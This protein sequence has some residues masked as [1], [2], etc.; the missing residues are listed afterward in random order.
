MGRALAISAVLLLVLGVI[1][2]ARPS[3]QASSAYAAFRPVTTRTSMEGEA[4]LPVWRLALQRL[5]KR[6]LSRALRA[7]A[8]RRWRRRSAWALGPLSGLVA[9]LFGPCGRLWRWL[10]G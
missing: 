10:L 5:F 6:V 4:Y 1:S 8:F 3:S 9:A 7:A 2:G